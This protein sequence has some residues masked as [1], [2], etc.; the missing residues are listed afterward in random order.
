MNNQSQKVYTE[1]SDAASAP[2]VQ[3]NESEPVRLLSKL[4]G[5]E[6]DTIIF[7]LKYL[8]ERDP[9]LAD[10]IRHL[11]G[12]AGDLSANSRSVIP[13][14]DVDLVECMFQ[15]LAWENIEH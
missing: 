4:S 5:D 2:E 8:E 10:K 15:K 13:K 9:A 14:E 6:S 3:L 1:P 12:K 11:Y 7:N